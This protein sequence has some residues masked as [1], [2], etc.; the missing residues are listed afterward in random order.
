MLIGISGTRMQQHQHQHQQGE[1]PRL[2]VLLARER[3]PTQV[4]DTSRAACVAVAQHV[5]ELVRV[6]TAEQPLVVGL[7]VDS[8]LTAVY[9]ELVRLHA[10]ERL[11]F[12]H[13]QPVV[14]HEY[15]GLAPHMRSLQ[16]SQAFLQQY[17]LDHIDVAPGTLPLLCSSFSL[18]NK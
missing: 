2:G 10:T 7:S 9:E 17:L 4:F 1:S 15:H 18:K 5:A 14:L 6:A 12:A 11:S 13:V 3:I 8:G 16:S